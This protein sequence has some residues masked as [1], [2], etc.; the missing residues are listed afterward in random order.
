MELGPQGAEAGGENKNESY[1]QTPCPFPYNEYN[2]PR[3]SARPL[4]HSVLLL[5]AH[6]VNEWGG[7]VPLGR[8]KMMFSGNVGC[9]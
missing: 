6:V 3:K 2:K 8:W 1:K 4:T 7:L 9:A 5:A